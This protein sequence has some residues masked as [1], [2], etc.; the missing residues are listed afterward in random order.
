MLQVSPN[1]HDTTKALF[2]SMCYSRQLS[3][4]VKSSLTTADAC[5]QLN[6]QG[7][8]HLTRSSF[9]ATTDASWLASARKNRKPVARLG[10]CVF[11]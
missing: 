5:A 7:M 10:A 4:P 3:H 11:K 9:R 8:M 1:L 2:W 6:L